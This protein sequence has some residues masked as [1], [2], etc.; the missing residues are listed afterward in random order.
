MHDELRKYIL[1]SLLT[2]AMFSVISSDVTGESYEEFARD[3]ACSTTDTEGNIEMKMKHLSFSENESY[4]K[5]TVEIENA[6]SVKITSFDNL[7]F[8]MKEEYEY[9]DSQS[10]KIADYDGSK[11]DLTLND[12]EGKMTI[13]Y[14]DEWFYGHIPNIGIEY[15]NQEGEN[16]CYTTTGSIT[17][18]FEFEL[19]STFGDTVKGNSRFQS[20]INET[21]YMEAMKFNDKVI[22]V[23]S[24][25]KIEQTDIIKKMINDSIVSTD[26]LPNS[27]TIFVNPRESEYNG[28]EI[29]KDVFVRT[30]RI[31][32]TTLP[33]EVIHLQQGAKFGEDMV[34]Y[35]E[36]E[37]TYLSW[38]TYSKFHDDYEMAKFHNN[39]PLASDKALEQNANYQR[40]ANFVAVIDYELR[41]HTNGNVTVFDLFRYVNNQDVITY[42][43]F[44][45]Y[46]VDNTDSK[47]GNWMD[48][49]VYSNGSTQANKYI[50]HERKPVN[51]SS[52]E[53]SIIQI[54]NLPFVDT[55]SPCETDTGEP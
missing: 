43:E 38:I 9:T 22:R 29:H 26:F 40:G 15:V 55:D 7:D 21:K 51:C 52:E 50:V 30:D 42:D 19:S 46:V 41:N 28:L 34:W 27:S 37:P 14:G 2:M 47:V 24:V 13:G 35:N 54:S 10:F 6:Q 11:I 33:H 23:Y 18:N 4:F 39:T 48:S 49:V 12:S 44:R 31:G 53:D 3:S 20:T 36:G 25:S 1:I 16:K 32:E 45:S 5:G 17:E 8:L